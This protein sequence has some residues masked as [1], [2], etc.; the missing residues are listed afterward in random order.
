MDGESAQPEKVSSETAM[1]PLHPKQVSVL[2]IRTAIGLA[3]PVIA[4]LLIDSF[5][6]EE[7][8]VPRFHISGAIALLALAGIVL[9]PARR[10]RAWGWREDE[11]ELHIRS[12]M[13]FR[14]LT[15]VPFGRVQHIDIAQ[16]PIE[17]SHGLSTLILHTAGTRGASVPLPGL[18]RGQAEHMRDRIRAKIRQDLV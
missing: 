7:L 16:G 10:Y 2:R 17:R 9:L 3:I 12:G 8:T 6:A 4:A 13:L 11:D 5:L 14:R 15:V 1:S 18:E